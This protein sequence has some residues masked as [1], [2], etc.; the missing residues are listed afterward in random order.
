MANDVEKLEQDAAILGAMAAQMD[1]YLNSDILFW[2]M[3]HSR[4]PVL[5][6]GGFLMRHYR[7]FNLAHLVSVEEPAPLNYVLKVQT[8]AFNIVLLSLLSLSLPLSFS[9]FISFHLYFTS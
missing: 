8:C 2:K 6:L 3:G 9:I 4:M 7:L 1:E 5:T